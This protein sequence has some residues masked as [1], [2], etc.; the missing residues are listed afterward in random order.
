M[1]FF[2]SLEQTKSSSGSSL[3]GHCEMFWVCHCDLPALLTTSW[4]KDNP[5]S[6]FWGYATYN[7]NI[8]SLMA[9]IL[10]KILILHT[11]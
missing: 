6:R 1:F 11:I 8:S 2:F 9:G 4:T 7:S 3:V 5:N 10:L